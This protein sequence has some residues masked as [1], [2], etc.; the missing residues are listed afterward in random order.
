MACEEGGGALLSPLVSSSWPRAAPRVPHPHLAP[1]LNL[2][3]A[4]TL[5]LSSS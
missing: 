3:L 2:P 5:S 1:C 4:L